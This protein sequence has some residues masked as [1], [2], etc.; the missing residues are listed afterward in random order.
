MKNSYWLGSSR[1]IFRLL[2]LC[3]FSPIVL[4]LA[5]L[6]PNQIL[7]PRAE[8]IPQSLTTQLTGPF[9]VIRRIDGVVLDSLDLFHKYFLR[10]EVIFVDS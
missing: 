2:G 10:Y 8:V 3:F 9:K 7:E 6:Q 4:P 1:S 5:H